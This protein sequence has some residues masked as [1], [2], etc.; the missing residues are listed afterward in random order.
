MKKKF[1][2]PLNVDASFFLP[3]EN[4]LRRAPALSSK[5]LMMHI[6]L[7]VFLRQIQWCITLVALF[8]EKLNWV[9]NFPFIDFRKIFKT[10]G[11]TVNTLKKFF[12]KSQKFLYHGS[13]L[14]IFPRSNSKIYK[15]MN[16][17]IYIWNIE[18]HQWQFEQ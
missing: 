1:L 8:Y 3:P 15:S 5:V 7:K 2:P 10:A 17:L 14:I 4:F 11:V 12:K 18:Y 13:I 16:N 9:Q 6:K